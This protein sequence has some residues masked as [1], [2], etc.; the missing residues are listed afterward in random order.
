MKFASLVL[1]SGLVAVSSVASA[2]TYVELGHTS[3]DYSE[4]LFGIEAKS[5]PTALRAVLGYELSKNLAVEGMLAV[6]M[7]SDNVSVLIPG[8]GRL[9]GK[10]EIDNMYGIFVKPKMNFTP[11]LEGFVRAG[12]VHAKGTASFPG[13]PVSASESGFS[14]GA[15]MSYALSKS[16]SLNVDY[17][18]YLDKSGAKADGFTFGVGFKF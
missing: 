8:F 13:V 14:Y 2:Q 16:T 11:E 18:R 9:S 10:F 6:G 5:S 1:A 17:M 12:Y 4:K 15:G 7:G 3:V